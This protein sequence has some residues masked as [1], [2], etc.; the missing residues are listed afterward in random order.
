LSDDELLE[1]VNNDLNREVPLALAPVSAIT[2]ARNNIA[3]AS[4][5]AGT[6]GEFS[7]K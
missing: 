5:R 3:A 1:A 2:V 7:G 4:S 6:T